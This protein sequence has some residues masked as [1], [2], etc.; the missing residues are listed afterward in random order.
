VA[1]RHAEYANQVA[2]GMRKAG[3]RIEVDLSDDTVGEKVRRAITAKHPAIL[4][5]GDHDLEAATVGLRLRGSEE[6]RRGVPLSEATAELA[7]L[8]KPPR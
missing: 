5:V 8:C 1:D 2:A 4:V 6:E 7:E 3:L